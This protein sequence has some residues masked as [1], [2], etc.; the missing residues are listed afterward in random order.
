MKFFRQ[1]LIGYTAAAIFAYLVLT[2]WQGAN[3]LLK[4]GFGGYVSG[5]KALQ[6]R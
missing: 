1:D 4:T 3:A 2:R 6:G 5:V